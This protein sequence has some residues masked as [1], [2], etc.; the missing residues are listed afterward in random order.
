MQGLQDADELSAK[1]VLE[2][3]LL[4]IHGAWQHVYFFVLNV[5]ALDRS[6]SSRELEH[7][8]LA[9]WLGCIPA[10]IF[11]PYQWRVQALFDDGPDRER[12]GEDLFTQLI[13]HN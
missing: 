9:K 11:F 7:R 13:L 2:T 1:A 4:S 6:D 8:W 5:Y 10:A 3:N 12:W